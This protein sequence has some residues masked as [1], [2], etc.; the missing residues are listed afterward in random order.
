WQTIAPMEWR[1]RVHYVAQKPVMFPGTLE[2]N[3]RMPF[4]VSSI[5]SDKVFSTENMLQYLAEID[6]PP[7]ML[8]QEAGT[9]SGGEAARAALIRALLMEP[10]ILLLDEP[11]AYLDGDSRAAVINLLNQ[12]VAVQERAIL[13][14]SHKDEDISELNKVS[15]LTVAVGKAGGE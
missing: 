6:L 10:E 4:K 15:I 8:S 1:T 13:V 11:T 7:S 3:F 5:L 14:V 12:W 2:E 9:L